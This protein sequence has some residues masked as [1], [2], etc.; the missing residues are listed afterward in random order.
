[1]PTLRSSILELLTGEAAST[2]RVSRLHNGV[3]P[4]LFKAI[5]KLAGPS[6]VSDH[7]KQRQRRQQRR[8]QQCLLVLLCGCRLVLSL[9]SAHYGV[10]RNIIGCSTGRITHPLLR[11]HRLAPPLATLAFSS[12][13]ETAPTTPKPAFFTTPLHHLHLAHN[14]KMVQFA[15]YTMPLMYPPQT[16]ISEHNFTREHCSLFDVSHMVQHL[17]TGPG[18]LAFL[19]FLT[20]ADLAK[21]S[22]YTST[23]SVFLNPT[24]GIVDDSIITMKAGRDQL[25]RYKCGV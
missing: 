15:G 6:K 21:L 3:R 17:F 13:T 9:P 10:P 20:P 25:C 16:H 12:T 11:V 2:Q 23:L 1:M 24:G 7:S 22:P 14:A 8:Q 4:C 5:P 18:A 19:E